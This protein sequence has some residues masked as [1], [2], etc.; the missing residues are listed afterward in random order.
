[1][2]TYDSAV[3]IAKTRCNSSR[4]GIR[5]NDALDND[6][7]SPERVDHAEVILF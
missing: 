1:M 6:A 3:L 4:V 5:L 2:N 7:S